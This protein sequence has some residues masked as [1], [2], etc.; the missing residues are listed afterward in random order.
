MFSVFFAKE[1][2]TD[3]VLMV[4]GGVHIVING[5]GEVH[6]TGRLSAV[7][8]ATLNGI[9][10]LNFLEERISKVSHEPPSSRMEPDGRQT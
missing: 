3:M 1:I 10:S 8:V 6:V 5:Y 2:Q 4:I 7:G 9:G